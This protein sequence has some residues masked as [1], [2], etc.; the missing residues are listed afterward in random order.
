M[1][2]FEQMF[3]DYQ[4]SQQKTWE[5]DRSLTVGASEVFDCWRKV[6]F[7][8]RGKELGYTE[9]EAEEDGWGAAERGNLIEEFWVV[10]ALDAMLPD[11]VGYLFAGSDQK[12]LIK[13]PVSATPDGLVT[14]LP[15]DAL[16]NYG[17][18]DIKSDCI[19]LELKS[20]DPRV[21]LA[22]AK[23]IHEGQAQMQLGLMNELTEFKP[24]FCVI[25]YVDASFLDKIK[26][27][28]VEYD[29][30]IYNAGKMRAKKVFET[31][32][33]KELPAEGKMT[34]ACKF[35]TWRFACAVVSEEAV[36]TE[37]AKAKDVD[38]EVYDRVYQLVADER[39]QAEIEKEAG[40]EK[41]RIRANIKQALSDANTKKLK[42]DRYSVSWSFQKGRKTLD[43]GAMEIDGIDLS[44]YEKEGPGFEV[45]RIKLDS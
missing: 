4:Q 28:V 38:Q 24:V 25:L 10:P 41:E 19:L 6:G 13:E 20:V 17:I 35:C 45:M 9:D 30:R 31:D 29:K 44:K 11:G 21:N 27:F 5:H 33:L 43:K 14:D 23:E 37:A 40:E 42:D 3:R 39:E 12:T 2:N 18:P 16:K 36:P 1:L 34:D 32:E 15:R 7:K 8:K 26:V 22:T